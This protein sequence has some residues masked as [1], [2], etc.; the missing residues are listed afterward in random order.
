[1]GLGWLMKSYGLFDSG[2]LEG[3]GEE[4]SEREMIF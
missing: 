4:R 2:I 1:M 3:R